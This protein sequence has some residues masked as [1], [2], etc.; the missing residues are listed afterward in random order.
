M[1]SIY[2]PGSGGGG[3]GTLFNGANVGTGAGLSFRDVSGGLTLN[4]R[5][6][7]G[8]NNVGIST[9]GDEIT[10]AYAPGGASCAGYDDANPGI[11]ELGTQADCTLGSTFGAFGCPLV[12]PNNYNNWSRST[13]SQSYVYR[14]AGDSGIATPFG[15][16]N[17]DLQLARVGNQYTQKKQCVILGKNNTSGGSFKNFMLGISN[18]SNGTTDRSSSCVGFFNFA[19]EDAI[20][21]GTLAIALKRSIAIGRNAYA[22]VEFTTFG[23]PLICRCDN[24]DHL[25]TLEF[26]TAEVMLLTGE[27]DLKT[28]ADST[29]TLPINT[30]FYVNE[31][32]LFMTSF[33]GTLTVQPTVR[34]GITGTPEKF[35]APTKTQLLTSLTKRQLFNPIL[36][37]DGE[38]S[39]VA[40]VTSGATGTGL[41]YK[42]RFYFKGLLV[43]NQVLPS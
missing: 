19:N 36:T 4:L 5:T 28:I 43:E 18:T 12:V 39:L 25:S 34:F 35:V 6:F 22:A 9:L 13:G 17:V 42:G 7:L 11:V 26:N 40:G 38:T 2:P 30:S 37:D 20:A 8:V 15:G 33:V 10:I 23:S 41:T 3:G 1:G 32:G 14:N 21:I 31:V 27:V 16:E 24:S 29:I